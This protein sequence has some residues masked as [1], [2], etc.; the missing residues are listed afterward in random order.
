M[1]SD[2]N[3]RRRGAGS[4]GGPGTGG[5]GIPAALLRQS[6]ENALGL[7]IGLERQ[8]AGPDWFLAKAERNSD[9]V[10]ATVRWSDNVNGVVVTIPASVASGAA[11]NEWRINSQQGSSNSAVVDTAAKTLTLTAAS[12]SWSWATVAATINAVWSGAAVTFGSGGATAGALGSQQFSGGTPPEEIGATVDAAAKTVT[13]RYISTDTLQQIKDAIDGFEIDSETRLL[14][15]EVAGTNLSATARAPGSN[16]RTFTE[17]YG[18]GQ[19]PGDLE[20]VDPQARAA[21]AAAQARADS[22]E[23]IA[24][25]AD[26]ALRSVSAAA[27]NAEAAGR[28]NATAIQT[29]AGARTSGDDLQSV[30]IGS[31]S[32][33]Q[34]ALNAQRTSAQPLEIVI[35]AD[36]SGS[37]GGTPYA[38]ENGDVLFVPPM[39]DSVEN[40]FNL[41]SGEADEGS[42]DLGA[43]YT[44]EIALTGYSWFGSGAGSVGWDGRDFIATLRLK[45]EDMV[46]GPYLSQFVGRNIRTQIGIINPTFM[47]ISVLRQSAGVYRLRVSLVSGQNPSAPNPIPDCSLTFETALARHSD[48]PE[49]A[50]ITPPSTVAKGLFTQDIYDFLAARDRWVASGITTA[51]QLHNILTDAGQMKLARLLFFDAEVI[52][53]FQGVQY[54]HK[55]NLVGYALPGE[56]TVTNLFRVSDTKIKHAGTTAELEALLTTHVKEHTD[57]FVFINAAFAHSGRNYT[58]GSLVSFPPETVVPTVEWRLPVIPTS[59]RIEPPSIA[60]PADIDGNYV[61]FLGKPDYKNVEVDQLEIWFKD[62]AVHNVSPFT[63]ESG[64][65]VIPFNVSA[66]EETQIGVTNADDY[67]RVLAVYRKS[68]Q[69][70]GQDTTVLGVKN[71]VPAGNGGD[72][73][74][75]EQKAELIGLRV[76]PSSA[77]PSDSAFK[78]WTVRSDSPAILGSSV[79]AQITV[80]G[81]TLA[82]Q[83]LTGS[84]RTFT[85]TDQI[86]RTIND[87]ITIDQ[88]VLN[89]DVALYDAESAGTLLATLHRDVTLQRVR[90]NVQSLNSGA[91]IGWNID[92]GEVADL[93][94]AHNATLTPSGGEDGDSALLRVK[95]DSTGNRTLALASAVQRDGRAQP[96]LSTG[97]NALDALFFHKIGSAWHYM[98]IIKNG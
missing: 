73:L 62:E 9:G 52:E 76:Q 19:R 12:A 3:I 10:Q 92:S 29:E 45:A 86:A 89:V 21:A 22:A 18:S 26:V 4:G 28:A 85:F 54:A 80:V 57:L 49:D 66:A 82:R 33:Y 61:L 30:G 75:N 6:G 53:T 65:F 51:T 17:F 37:R 35:T 5:G 60:A 34:S 27:Q 59:I 2:S 31:A 88:T 58:R 1:T 56:S 94:L 50:T 55:R 79:W 25:Q 91:A 46:Y 63:P 43:A 13:L 7:F 23:T 71:Q 36:I 67:I 16:S 41:G 68:G 77:I 72:G 44:R 64:P 8:E 24:Q 32:S 42:P 40:R 39:S 14:A 96:T 20:A 90:P 98:G 81:Q 69:Y 93:T 48:L 74:T 87:N 95:Q 38:Y 97:A 11:G 15:T 83:R 84:V 70:V 47:V 78:T